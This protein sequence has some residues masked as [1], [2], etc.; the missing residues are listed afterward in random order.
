LQEIDFLELFEP[1]LKNHGYDWEIKKKSPD[2]HGLAIL[3]K[4]NVLLKKDYRAISYDEINSFNSSFV[5]L[6]T[7]NIAQLL[8]FEIISTNRTIIVSNTHLYWRP[9]A[10]AIKI[11]QAWT[12]IES[13]F[14]F[15]GDSDATVLLCGDWN[16]MPQ[17]IL[18]RLL[19][20]KE[21]VSEYELEHVFENV[22]DHGIQDK[23]A[24]EKVLE[25]YPQIPNLKSTYKA[26][27]GQEP[28]FTTTSKDFTGVLDYIFI[29]GEGLVIQNV[30]QICDIGEIPNA[31][32]PSDHVPV[33]ATFAFN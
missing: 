30:E 27:Y 24:C 33:V 21:T 32:F 17:D 18:Y 22:F 11:K 6:E 13:L 23:A 2:G 26:F 15:K 29:F 3:Y 31:H 10:S 4:R 8:K 9:E 1:E 7:G 12:L 28:P 25:F 16:I 5:C 20:R 14:D 19:T